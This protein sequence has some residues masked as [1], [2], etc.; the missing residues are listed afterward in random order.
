[1]ELSQ[2]KSDI[3]ALLEEHK[4]NWMNHVFGSQPEVCK[5]FKEKQVCQAMLIMAIIN[6]AEHKIKNPV[7]STQQEGWDLRFTWKYENQYYL[8]LTMIIPWE[9]ELRYEINTFEEG[10]P[11]GPMKYGQWDYEKFTKVE[12]IQV[13]EFAEDLE[14]AT[15][16]DIEN[17]SGTGKEIS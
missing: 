5:T 3:D 4:E 13:V 7:V 15:V 6:V 10:D 11:D 9:G 1:M 2:I 14:N 8:S 17:G 12:G 16:K